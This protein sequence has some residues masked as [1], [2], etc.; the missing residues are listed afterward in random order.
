MLIVAM[1]ATLV[2]G[3]MWIGSMNSERDDKLCDLLESKSEFTEEEI[4]MFRGWMYP[5]KYDD[6]NPSKRFR[7]L[8][9]TKIEK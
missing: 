1:I 6:Y 4:D 2:L 3:F 7:N 8:Y 5:G 9:K